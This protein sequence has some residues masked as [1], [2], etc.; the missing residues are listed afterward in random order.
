MVKSLVQLAHDPKLAKKKS[1]KKGSK[2]KGLNID[3]SEDVD[4]IGNLALRLIE[5]DQ[6]VLEKMPSF[7]K[8]PNKF[9]ATLPKIRFKVGCVY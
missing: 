4:P 2:Q 1:I 6:M 8:T 9:G 7:V 3:D 5:F